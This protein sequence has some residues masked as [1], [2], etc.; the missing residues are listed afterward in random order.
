[1]S[2]LNNLTAQR[3]ANFFRERMLHGGDTRV[4]HQ[5]AQRSRDH[6]VGPR[7]PMPLPVSGKRP[8]EDGP[9]TPQTGKRQGGA[10]KQRVKIVARREDHWASV[11]WKNH[12]GSFEK[13]NP[14]WSAVHEVLVQM[15][16]AGTVSYNK[17]K[18][19]LQKYYPAHWS[20]AYGPGDMTTSPLLFAQALEARLPQ[21]AIEKIEYLVFKDKWTAPQVFTTIE[22]FKKCYEA[23]PNPPSEDEQFAEPSRLE[24]MEADIAALKESIAGM[25]KNA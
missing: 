13:Q 10:T 11:E 7:G 23:L 18:D 1:M 21:D 5:S 8:A 17:D 14:N 12:D 4:R 19:E 25:T 3:K 20:T 16:M 6:L 22:D 2:T 24:K 15:K 9:S